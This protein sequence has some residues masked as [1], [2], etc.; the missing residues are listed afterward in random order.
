LRAGRFDRA[1][2]DT[3]RNT[4]SEV[5]L[6]VTD[7]QGPTFRAI[8]TTPHQEK[9]MTMTRTILLGLLLTF[10]FGVSAGPAAAGDYSLADLYYDY[11][12]Y[13]GEPEIVWFLY[14]EFEDGTV[15]EIGPYSSKRDAAQ[16]QF[17]WAEHSEATGYVRGSVEETVIVKEWNL[18]RRF[19]T[20]DVA[21]AYAELIEDFGY[22]TDIDPVYSPKYTSS[23]LGSL[24]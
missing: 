14:L 2:T 1:K 7:R 21:E 16:D 5:S 6:S 8:E 23:R 22:A 11:D 20:R 19:D 9:T 15:D 12:L 17:W 10:G 4:F 3:A 18:Y 24:K 13:Y